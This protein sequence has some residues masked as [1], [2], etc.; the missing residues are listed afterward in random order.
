MAD[1]HHVEVLVERVHGER[2]RR[3]G[4]GRQAV[5]LAGDSDDVRRVAAAGALRVVGVDRAAADRRHRVL[6]EA[7]L[8]ERVGVDLHLHVELVAGAQ[9][10][11]DHRRHR[12][13]VLV[14]LQADRARAALLQQRRDVIRRAL[15]EEA[16]V[17]RERL[18][19]LQHPPE[20]HRAR[21]GDADRH[22]PQ[23]AAE[24]R[25]DPGGDRLLAQP[26]R[27]EV[28]VHVQRA[29]G[30][31]HPL[32]RAHVRVRPD[33]EARVDA[34]HRLRV[35]G[36]ADPGDAAVLDADV[37]LDDA[38]HRVDHE[39]VRDHEV[40]RAV[41]RRDGA[42][43]A[44]A[45]AHRLAAAEHGLV[46]GHE[47]VALDL[48]PQLRVA[49]PD[50]VARRRAEQLRVL[51]AGDLLAHPQMLHSTR[52]V[53]ARVAMGGCWAT[54]GVEANAGGIGETPRGAQRRPA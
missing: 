13:P 22:R 26:S 52:F 28:D 19:R 53:D 7:G 24:H 29:R 54:R 43:R 6:V 36:L 34:V 9:R 40:E 51:L 18:T 16:E 3:V 27:V 46:A 23:P 31:D 14:D 44:E 11:V 8:V 30:R 48:R 49:E 47:Q 38:L 4:R 50:A 35:A 39:H 17:E 10:G 12:A 20:V 42:V 25:R 33:H 45:V 41:G 2:V 15:A 21:R 32:A 5:R 37:A 1:H